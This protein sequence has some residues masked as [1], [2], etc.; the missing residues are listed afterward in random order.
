MSSSLFFSLA[1]IEMD[2]K[3]TPQGKIHSIM[4][5]KTFLEDAIRASSS[6]SGINAD[7]FLP[8]LIYAVLKAKPPRLHSNIQFLSHFSQ[9]SGEQLYYLANLVSLSP[10]AVSL[11][12][13]FDRIRPFVSSNFFK[14]NISVC[15]RTISRCTCEANRCCLRNSS[16]CS[17]RLRR[18]RSTGNRFARTSLSITNSII[19]A[20]NSTRP[21]WISIDG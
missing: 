10:S 15:R 9:P 3:T 13:F 4:D 7:S 19:I 21:S 11:L 1:L 18:R 16:V 20:R 17:I 12:S 14:L 8:A 5:C 2:S 6:S